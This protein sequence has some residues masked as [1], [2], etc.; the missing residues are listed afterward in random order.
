MKFKLD[1]RVRI[2]S[3][4]REAIVHAISATCDGTSYKVK[5]DLVTIESYL[6]GDQTSTFQAYGVKESDLEPLG[7]DE[8][9]TPK[10]T[11]TLPETYPIKFKNPLSDAELERF[12]KQF[13][14]SISGAGNTFRTPIIGPCDHSWTI[15]DSG[16]SR[17][18]F[19]TKCDE[20]KHDSNNIS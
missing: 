11:I 2:R 3:L 19:C 10:L 1:E 8:S 16:F 18:E 15:Y 12:R 14:D 7:F 17:Y 9:A 4:D 13:H 20:K 6:L 5:Y